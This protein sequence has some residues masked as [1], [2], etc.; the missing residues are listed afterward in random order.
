MPQPTTAMKTSNTL[1]ISNSL[2]DNLSLCLT[3]LTPILVEVT[4]RLATKALE[5]GPVIPAMG[6]PVPLTTAHEEQLFKYEQHLRLTQ[7]LTQAVSLLHEILS[8]DNVINNNAAREMGQRHIGPILKK[9][10]T[11]AQDSYIGTIGSSSG[12][13]SG[14]QVDA[15]LRELFNTHSKE[16]AAL[17]NSSSPR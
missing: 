16:L 4:G 12:N 7:G 15:S 3:S 8:D 11:L 2:S 17:M 10:E 14:P 1:N 6:L 5:L 13:P 9:L